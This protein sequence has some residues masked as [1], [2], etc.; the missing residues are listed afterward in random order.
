MKLTRRLRP[1]ANLKIDSYKVIA[2]AVEEGIERGCQRAHKH[3]DHP[4]KELLKREI[5]TAVMNSLSEVL[6]WPDIYKD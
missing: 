5:E 2:R 3:V 6:I 4:S 1:T